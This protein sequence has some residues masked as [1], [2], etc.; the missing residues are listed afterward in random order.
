MEEALDALEDDNQTIMQKDNHDTPEEPHIGMTH[1]NDQEQGDG[2]QEQDDENQEQDDENQMEKSYQREPVVV[3]EIPEDEASLGSPRDGT[4]EDEYDDVPPAWDDDNWDYYPRILTNGR[5]RIGPILTLPNFG[6]EESST[7]TDPENCSLETPDEPHT[8]TMHSHD[9]EEDSIDSDDKHHRPEPIVIS[10]STDT[11]MEHPHD[12]KEDDID[13]LAEHH[14]LDPIDISESS[15]SE[16]QGSPRD[17]NN[18]D[19]NN[20]TSN[21]WGED[22]E[23]DTE[24]YNWDGSHLFSNRNYHPP[25]PTYL[26][27]RNA[28]YSDSVC[29]FPFS[30]QASSTCN[31]PEHHH[32]YDDDNIY[33]AWGN[34][35]ASF[36]PMNDT[37]S[38]SSQYTVHIE[39]GGSTS[40]QGVALY[41]LPD[42]LP[43]TINLGPVS[44]ILLHGDPFISI[45][46]A[47][48]ARQMRTRDDVVRGGAT[49]AHNIQQRQ[50]DDQGNDLFN[51]NETDNLAFQN[52]RPRRDLPADYE[53]DISPRIPPAQREQP[54][55]RKLNEYWTD[56]EIAA[57]DEG[58]RLYNKRW[59]F[60]K[61]R[62]PN[63]LSNRTNVQLKDKA[64]N[65]ARQRQRDG[66]PLEHYEGCG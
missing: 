35:H 45:S 27:R 25:P 40:E 52:N 63:A 65:V 58:L 53:R 41:D 24:Y 14:R 61:T 30:Q 34:E 26:N 51:D 48:Y 2:D 55:L 43:N 9:Q 38:I 1:A 12:Q 18:Q 16:D 15:E 62:Y 44:P 7:Y 28:S 6:I 36:D 19:E 46:V 66:V 42:G 57:L 64:R 22:N 39:D 20:D 50:Q 3:S 4:Y 29:M 37:N 17:D 23:S 8:G 10:A 49:R 21:A 60:I 11:R 5:P 13:P 33:K 32:V 54:N 47:E 56:E 59:A 31:D